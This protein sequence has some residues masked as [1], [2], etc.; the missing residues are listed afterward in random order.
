MLGT[1]ATSGQAMDVALS[2]NRAYIAAGNI[3]G[4]QVFD[5]T[6]PTNGLLLGGYSTPGSAKAVSVAGIF[7]FVADG[8]FGIQ[9][10]DVANP[11]APFLAGTHDTPCGATRIVANDSLCYVADTWGFITLRL[12]PEYSIGDASGNGVITSA[13]IIH[14]V[15][16]VFK[17]GLSPQPRVDAEDTDC[18]GLVT[19]ADI[20]FL[21]NHSTG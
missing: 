15:N 16:Y 9:A 13:D 11:T 7:A 6:D 18:N 19:S 17:G 5:M 8:S 14:L 12:N 4:L 10:I 1:L 20:I 3:G 21:A 2:G